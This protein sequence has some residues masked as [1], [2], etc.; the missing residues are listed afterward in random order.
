MFRDTAKFIGK[1]CNEVC[2]G[3]KGQ[4]SSKKFHRFPHKKEELLIITKNYYKVNII[5]NIGNTKRLLIII[6]GTQF[7]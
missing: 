6:I 7:F 1:L 5:N 3:N 2:Y 4:R